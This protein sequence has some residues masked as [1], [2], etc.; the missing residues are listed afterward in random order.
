MDLE[1]HVMPG[2]SVSKTRVNALMLPGIH[3]FLM[4]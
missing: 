4:R 3:A 2:H 1:L